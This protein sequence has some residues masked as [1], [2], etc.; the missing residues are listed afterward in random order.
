[1]TISLWLVVGFLCK[2]RYT[3]HTITRLAPGG[4]ASDGCCLLS[5]PRARVG[6]LSWFVSPI[7]PLFVA[8]PVL[9]ASEKKQTMRSVYVTHQYGE[10]GD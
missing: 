6:F 3:V 9:R 4:S 1:M 5:K 7:S 8:S 10:A 2:M